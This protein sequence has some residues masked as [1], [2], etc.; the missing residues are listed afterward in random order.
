MTEAIFA[1]KLK[2]FSG[3]SK[4]EDQ[5]NADLSQ[6][7]KRRGNGGGWRLALAEKAAS[8]L[9]GRSG[10][11]LLSGSGLEGRAKKAKSFG[12]K[13]KSLRNAWATLFTLQQ[14]QIKINHI[15]YFYSWDDKRSFLTM[16]SMP[17]LR[18]SGCSKTVWKVDIKSAAN[19][20]S[21]NLKM[22]ILNEEFGNL[23]IN[24]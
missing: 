22:K 23:K 14:P 21:I 12:T 2:L 20:S 5:L 7:W 15:F 3:L 16:G 4:E 6:E 1:S 24:F 19:A 17:R 9:N 18:N 13:F 8:L 10:L 11:S